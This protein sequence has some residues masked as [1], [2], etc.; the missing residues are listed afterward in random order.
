MSLDSGMLDGN[1]QVLSLPLRNSVSSPVIWVADTTHGVELLR[2]DHEIILVESLAQGLECHN[3]SV[4]VS[5]MITISMADSCMAA[6]IIR[7]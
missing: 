6:S 7:P 3:H 1:G 5:I 2:G 4:N